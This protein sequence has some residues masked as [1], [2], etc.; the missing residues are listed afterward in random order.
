MKNKI[1][2]IMLAF[3]ML[4]E[5]TG[6][7]VVAETPEQTVSIKT[8]AEYPLLNALNIVTDEFEEYDAA[9]DIVTRGEAS[10]YLARL[11]NAEIDLN[12]SAEYV[13]V[14]A[15]RPISP[16]IAFAQQMGLFENMD[17]RR[18]RPDDSITRE[19]LSIM[20]CRILGFGAMYGTEAD[21]Y[22]NQYYLQAKQSEIF[23]GVS[24]GDVFTRG[25]FLKILV[26]ILNADICRQVSF[27][28]DRQFSTKSGD[29]LLKERFQ[30]MKA[31]GIVTGY[32]FINLHGNE[33]ISAAKIAVSQELY[34]IDTAQETDYTEYVGHEVEYYLDF[35]D[36]K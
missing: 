35:A 26:N 4:F 12:A 20:A 32:G 6:L 34:S 18:F 7:M 27:G 25:D 29:T 13:D 15:H 3:I 19:E 16:Y 5:A 1:L 17:R 8:L 31:N 30:V 33:E 9:E 23:I 24:A 14:E 28:S 10:I 22:P 21:Y 36:E 11:Y 2:T